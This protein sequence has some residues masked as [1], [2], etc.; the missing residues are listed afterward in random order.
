M[1][2]RSA[3]SQSCGSVPERTAQARLSGTACPADKICGTAGRRN[4]TA[5]K[6]FYPADRKSCHCDGNSPRSGSWC[7]RGDENARRCPR[8]TRKNAFF[9]AP[10]PAFAYLCSRIGSGDG[11]AVRR[12]GNRV[13]FPDSPAAVSSLDCRHYVSATGWLSGSTGKAC[14]QE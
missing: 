2:S 6:N 9:L 5:D 3:L 11:C 7:G 14:L 13:Q 1:P 8:L 12:R 10:A 4:G